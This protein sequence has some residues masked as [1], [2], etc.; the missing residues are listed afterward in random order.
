MLREVKCLA[1][2]DHPNVNRYYGA[3]LEPTWLPKASSM[4][5]T[6]SI[7]ELNGQHRMLRDI[8]D[9]VRSSRA[10]PLDFARHNREDQLV[11]TRREINYIAYE[12]EN[13]SV[14]HTDVS[15]V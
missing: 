14:F 7:H 12:Y 6:G 13:S 3:W 8:H 2:C 10:S 5:R 4:A 15:N 11:V 9:I 1:K